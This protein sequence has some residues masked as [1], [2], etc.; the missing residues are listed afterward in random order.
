M[1]TYQLFAVFA[2]CAVVLTGCGHTT[3]VVAHRGYWRAE[4]SAQNS[5]ASLAKAAEIGVYGSEFDVQ[6]TKDHELVVYHDDDINGRRISDMP[7]AELKDFKLPNGERLPTLKDYLEEALKH[8]DLQLVLEIKTHPS[9]EHEMEV[10]N[11]VLQMIHAANL[12]KRVDYIS[13]SLPICKELA[14]REPK[15]SVAYLKEA[16][17]PAELKKIGINGLDYHH[18]V[19]RIH[20]PEW[21][22]E[23]RKC[24]VTVN[25]WTVNEEPVYRELVEKEVDFITTDYPVDVQAFIDKR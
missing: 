15:A 16:L 24:N 6:M 7:F 22:E 2:V 11:R 5:I 10:V 12:Q 9:M 21:I 8:P 17:S 4:G 20:H 1:K 3:K 23:A 13:F 14:A 18:D 25:A 19:L